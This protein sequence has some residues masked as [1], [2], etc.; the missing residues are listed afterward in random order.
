MKIKPHEYQHKSIS[1]IR[2]HFLA[3]LNSVLLQSSTGSGKTVI[4]AYMISRAA[5]RGNTVY[6]VAHRDYLLSQTSDTLRAFGVPHGIISPAYNQT[7]DPVQVASVMTIIRRLDKLKPGDLLI[8]DEAHRSVA[9]S[10]RTI[11][12]AWPKARVVGL[13]ATP[14]RLDGKPLGDVFQAIVN[15]PSMRWLIDNGYLCDFE[16]YAPPSPGL[17]TIGIRKIAGDYDQ[18]EAAKRMNKPTITGSAVEHYLKLLKGK[19]V[20][21][22]CGSIKHSLD[23]AEQFNAAGISA[24]HIDGTTP[25]HERQR[26]IS[27][28]EAGRILALTN[29]NLVVE[30]FDLPAV[31]GVILLRLTQSLVFFLQ[32]VGRALRKAEG[33]TKAIILDH[34]GLVVHADGTVNHGYPDEEREWSLEGK[35]GG[36]GSRDNGGGVIIHQCKKCFYVYET[37]PESCPSCGEVTP[38][39]IRKIEMKDGELKKLNREEI[40][41][42]KK[43]R[44]K[45]QGRAQT[46][47]E[48]IAL[49]R[50]RGMKNPAGWAYFIH[51]ARQKRRS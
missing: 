41:R 37:G 44:K 40:I 34:V 20:V 4:A 2:T 16:I 35:Q 47:E 19:R 6:F 14:Q 26:I 42:E 22:F 43:D 30:G 11:I 28:F 36:S 25:R 3:G 24:A 21:I 9:K 7:N 38:I 18:G 39:K 15:G 1:D 45:E 8:I 17:D 5:E 50:A 48:L 23:V 10:H 46:M 33:K 32:A 29:V 27:E 13:T 12:E 51:N 49:G 31:E